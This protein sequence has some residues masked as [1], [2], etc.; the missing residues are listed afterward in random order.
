MFNLT[1]ISFQHVVDIKIID[2]PCC[3]FLV[4]AIWGAFY[5]ETHLALAWPHLSTQ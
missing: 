5:I 4:F 3:I 2:E 1:K